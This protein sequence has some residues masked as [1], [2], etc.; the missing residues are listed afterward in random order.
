MSKASE[1]K[2][3]KQSLN[4]FKAITGETLKQLGLGLSKIKPEVCAHP[5]EKNQTVT[6]R[7]SMNTKGGVVETSTCVSKATKGIVTLYCSRN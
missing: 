1:E 2:V 5:L 3:A 7:V 4:T 6:G